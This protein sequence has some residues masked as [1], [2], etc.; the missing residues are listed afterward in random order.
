MFSSRLTKL[1]AVAFSA[2]LLAGSAGT[3]FADTPWEMNHPRRDEVNDRLA[4]QDHRIDRER[5]DGEIGRTDVRAG[6]GGVDGRRH[7][8]E[9]DIGLGGIVAVRRDRSGLDRYWRRMPLSGAKDRRGGWTGTN[10]GNGA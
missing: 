8:I 10:G 6:P 7:V 3:A 4:H 9:G 2:V 5:R 1:A